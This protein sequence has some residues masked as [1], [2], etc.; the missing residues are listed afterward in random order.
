MSDYRLNF[1]SLIGPSDT[2]RFYDMIDIVGPD[3]HLTITM[4]SGDDS[5]QLQTIYK[6]LETNNFDFNTKGGH[7]GGKYQIVATRKVE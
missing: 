5:P 2:D 7:E 3:D 4:D 6:V 1:G